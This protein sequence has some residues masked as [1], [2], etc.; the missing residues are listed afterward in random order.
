[1][2]R[3]ST[4]TSFVTPYSAADT[5]PAAGSDAAFGANCRGVFTLVTGVTY[6][7]D[8][9]G[10]DAKLIHL[11]MQGDAAIV[12]TSATLEETDLSMT[13]APLCSDVS[14]QW[15]A[16]HADR[17]TSIAEGTGWAVTSDVGSTSG[18]TQ[19]GFAM[20]VIDQA[21]RRS[22]LK[23]V[24][25]GTG[26]EARVNVWGKGEVTAIETKAMERKRKLKKAA[27]A[28]LIGAVLALVCR[29]LPADYRGP[30]ETVIKICSGGF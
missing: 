10:A 22:R 13:E 6:Y 12:I 16:A 19:G 1:M 26:G 2:G 21:A 17:I 4:S 20:N 28:A 30:C 9:G 11:M 15:F 8:L 7:Y 18:G 23:V 5:S 29:V 27:K 14:G 3:Q 24:V 25:G